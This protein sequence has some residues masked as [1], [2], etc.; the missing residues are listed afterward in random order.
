M[1]SNNALTLWQDVI[2]DAEQAC[3]IHLEDKLESYLVSLLIRYSNKPDAVKQI[4]G[5]SFLDALQRKTHQRNASLQLVGDQCLLLAGLFPRITET[6]R[7]KIDY[8]VDLGRGSYASISDTAN[9]LYGSLAL[10]F[11]LL[12]DVLQSIRQYPDL[13]PLEAYEQWHAVGSQHALQVLQFYTKR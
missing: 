11:V 13:L 1:I 9:D 7:V 8:F 10:Q 4:V 2:H 5:T 3:S 6:R 12:M